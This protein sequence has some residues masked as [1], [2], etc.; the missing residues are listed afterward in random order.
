[1]DCD[2]SPVTETLSHASKRKPEAGLSLVEIMVTLSIIAV[3][4]T[5][6]LLTIPTRQIYKQEADLLREALEHTASRSM[7]TGQPMGLLIEGQSYSS[8]IW[9]NGTWRLVTRYQLPQDIYIQIDGK[10]PA[11][12]DEKSPLV[13]AVIFDPLGHTYPVSIELARQNSVTILTLQPDGH[14]AIEVR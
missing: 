14:V 1:V 11:P 2:L 6:I 12:K 10:H 8:A 13:P 5:L 3:A 9:Q 4:T 7:L